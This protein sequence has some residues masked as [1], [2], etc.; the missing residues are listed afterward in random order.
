[1]AKIY[2]DSIFQLLKSAYP[3]GLSVKE[4]LSLLSI[5]ANKKTQLRKILRQFAQKKISHKSN[6][7]YYLSPKFVDKETIESRRKSK[8]RSHKNTEE[9]DIGVWIYRNGKGFI[10]GPESD[11]KFAL[12]NIQM[13]VLIH[14]V[15]VAVLR[16]PP[17]GLVPGTAL[18]HGR[19]DTRAGR[20]DRRR[21]GRCR[22][23]QSRG[24]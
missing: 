21:T 14:G 2:P 6:N 20:G 19:C 23:R 13:P 9:S 15:S 1:M 12:I 16:A 24:C 7:R 10:Q 8:S 22:A 5:G 18:G 4:M 3:K 11:Q 17:L